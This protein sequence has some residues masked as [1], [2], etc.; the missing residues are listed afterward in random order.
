[1][2]ADLPLIIFILLGC[3][4]VVFGVLYLA[5]R[6]IG[7]LGRGLFRLAG[8]VTGADTAGRRR[9]ALARMCPRPQCRKVEYRQGSFCSQCGARLGGPKSGSSP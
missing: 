8:C 9:Q 6:V 2:S 7:G 3:V 4:A 1:M 5:C